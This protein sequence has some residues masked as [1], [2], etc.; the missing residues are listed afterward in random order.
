MSSS[1]PPKPSLEYERKQAKKLLDQLRRGAADAVQRAHAQ[2]GSKAPTTD[3]QFKL[4]DAQFVIA[5][6]Y[7][8]CSWPRMVEYFQTLQRQQCSDLF[9]ETSHGDYEKRAQRYLKMHERRD[10]FGARFFGAYVPRLYGL[11]LDEVLAAPVSIEDARLVVARE[12]QFP[13]WD[14]LMARGAK[15]RDPWSYHDSP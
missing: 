13:N 6:E 4:S 11:T 2:L 12:E 5:R 15:T 9:R 10:P 8:F 7:G 14:A 3:E 1:L